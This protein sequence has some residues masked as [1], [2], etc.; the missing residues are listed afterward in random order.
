MAGPR[1][2]FPDEEPE[3][4]DESQEDDEDTEGDDDVNVDDFLLSLH[5]PDPPATPTWKLCPACLQET[6]RVSDDRCMKCGGQQR[7]R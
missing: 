6:V 1:Y 7:E 5:R 2:Y 3:E 4:D